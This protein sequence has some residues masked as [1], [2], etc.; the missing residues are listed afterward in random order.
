M[1]AE[2]RRKQRRGRWVSDVQG[3]SD[4]KFTYRRM[5]DEEW[6]HHQTVLLSAERD[7]HIVIGD[8]DD[9]ICKHVTQWDV[10]GDDGRPVPVDRNVLPEL[11]RAMRFGVALVVM[12][13]ARAPGAKGQALDGAESSK[14][15]LAV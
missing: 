1:A 8:A 13:D 7:V 14:R 2:T 12:D 11:P 10:D 6:V 15:P 9:V 4:V 3:I 5:D